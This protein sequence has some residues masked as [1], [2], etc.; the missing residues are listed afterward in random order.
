MQADPLAAM[1]AAGAS[2]DAYFDR[3]GKAAIYAQQEA[4][5][6]ALQAETLDPDRLK[7]LARMQTLA[8]GRRGAGGIG[9]AYVDAQLGQDKRRSAG[10]ETIRGIQDTGVT[11]DTGIAGY[12][13]QSRENAASRAEARR[14]AGI[15]GARG[16]LTDQENRA[17]QQQKLQNEVNLLNKEYEQ[18]VE[19]GKYNAAREALIRQGQAAREVVE[20]NA[21][22]VN[23]QVKVNISVS[24]DENK[25]RK[26]AVENKLEVAK[27][28]SDERLE[29]NKELFTNEVKLMELAEAR[30]KSLSEMVTTQLS[31]SPLAMELQNKLR[32]LSRSENPTE[33]AETEAALKELE[34]VTIEELIRRHDFFTD[35]YAD[36][37]TLSDRIQQLRAQN[38]AVASAPSRMN[39]N[40]TTIETIE[41]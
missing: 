31:S 23:N 25:A 35:I 27:K 17:S 40:T 33:Y 8:G 13:A 26:A 4:D 2:S 36:V 32:K 29:L 5:E 21:D 22:D 15:A 7:K 24:E 14:V 20:V 16:L 19:T 12:G 34:R 18:N 1:Q 3:A 41:P 38:T 11:T 30:A 28:R 9:Q 6:R 37:I 10:L 39:P